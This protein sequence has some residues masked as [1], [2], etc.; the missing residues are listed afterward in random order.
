MSVVICPL[1]LYYDHGEHPAHYK[2]N[3]S[4]MLRQYCDIAGNAL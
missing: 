2:E 4:K 1:A 3:L